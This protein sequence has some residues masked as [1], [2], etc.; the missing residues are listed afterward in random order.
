[1]KK[2]LYAL[3]LISMLWGGCVRYDIHTIKKGTKTLTYRIN[4]TN[5]FSEKAY[6]QASTLVSGILDKD[7]EDVQIKSFTISSIKFDLSPNTTNKASSVAVESVY[8]TGFRSGRLTSFENFNLDK[9]TNTE[10]KDFLD[11]AGLIVVNL[12]VT[13]LLK[14]LNKDDLRLDIQGNVVP[15]GQLASFTLNVQIDYSVD[16]THCVD[17]IHPS[18]APRCII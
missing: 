4:S 12:E 1:M 16:F 6:F 17:S 11:S 5:T 8:I 18:S 13:N 3:V 9:G 14:G 10:V 7:Y 2:I 15:R